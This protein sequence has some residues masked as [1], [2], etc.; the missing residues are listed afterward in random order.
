MKVFIVFCQCT[1]AET[2]QND[3]ALKKEIISS[4]EK[5]LF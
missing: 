1:S 3:V 5:C 2:Y 4:I